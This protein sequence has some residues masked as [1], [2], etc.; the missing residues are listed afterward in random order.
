M[1]SLGT[2]AQC[3]AI[4][5]VKKLFLMLRADFLCFSLW[6]LLPLLSLRTT[7]ESL[8]PPSCHPPWRYLYV[9]L[10]FPVSLLLFRLNRMNSHNLS[11]SSYER[12][13]SPIIIFM[14]SSG[15]SAAGPCLSCW[16]GRGQGSPGIWHQWLPTCPS[17]C[18][19]SRAVRPLPSLGTAHCSPFW[20]LREGDRAAEEQLQC[21]S[22]HS[23]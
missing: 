22:T 20:V 6:T 18:T 5:N 9:L 4:L 21:G 19:H 8:A 2:R 23:Y 11:L 16:T 15:P 13:S 3:S 10:R 12:Y 1:L 14:P 7:E 17:C